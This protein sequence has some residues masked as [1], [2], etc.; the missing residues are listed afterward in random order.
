[1]RGLPRL[2]VT[3][4]E[5]ASPHP[6]VTV[7]A[8]YGT[9]GVVIG[10]RVAERLGVEFLDR[11]IP[12]Y[13]AE[14]IGIAE[15]S[16][17]AVDEGPRSGIDRLIANLARVANPATATGLSV[18][19]IDLEERNMRA[20]IEEFMVRASRA[21]GVVLGRGGAVVLSEVPGAL[22]VYLGGPLEARIEETMKHEQIDRK[23][24]ERRVDANDRARREYVRSA[25]GV[26]GD[27]PSLYHLM[28]DAPAIGVDACIDLIVAASRFRLEQARAG[29]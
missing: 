1:M 12:A 29:G 10:P 6:V 13:V 8:L 17:G 7:A 21:G 15:K 27:D 24:A 18:E 9:G 16:V 23:E 19:R 2:I 26:D 28:I 3:V 5:G 22:H 20:E 4:P 11:A 14:R 25:Y